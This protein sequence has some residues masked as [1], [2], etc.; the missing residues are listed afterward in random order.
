MPGSSH[1]LDGAMA[2]YMPAGPNATVARFGLIDR[3][4]S[5]VVGPKQ[6]SNTQDVAPHERG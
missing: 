3:S 6:V 4:C 1:V 2:L 5:G